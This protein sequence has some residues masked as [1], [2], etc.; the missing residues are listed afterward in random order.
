MTSPEVPITVRVKVETEQINALALPYP[1]HTE[2]GYGFHDWDPE[3]RPCLGRSPG[4]AAKEAIGAPVC[5]VEALSY[6]CRDNGSIFSTS[7]RV[8]NG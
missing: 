5:A 8:S 4:C 3:T 2:S 7:S 1:V 6:G